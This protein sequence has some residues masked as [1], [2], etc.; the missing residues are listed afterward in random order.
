MQGDLSGAASNSVAQ[1]E[2]YQK[3]KEDLSTNITWWSPAEEDQ[4]CAPRLKFCTQ[5]GLHEISTGQTCFD[6]RPLL[7]PVLL[8][9][10]KQA[11][12]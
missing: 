7:V 12:D 10:K 1:Q 2:Q 4:S 9:H 6:N 3:I 8:N 11:P 5:I